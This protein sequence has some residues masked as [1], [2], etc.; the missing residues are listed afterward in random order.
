MRYS[1]LPALVVIGASFASSR[2]FSESE[3]ISVRNLALH[4]R[5]FDT[6]DTI[7]A[8]HVMD[9]EGTQLVRRDPIYL[10][11]RA[12]APPIAA[13]VSHPLDFLSLTL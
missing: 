13:Y 9:E 8:R 12:G 1:I 3:D 7:A 5:N 11:R 6:D 2:P 10:Q 4:S